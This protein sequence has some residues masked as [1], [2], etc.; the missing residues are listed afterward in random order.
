MKRAVAL[1]RILPAA[2]LLLLA[3]ALRTHNIDA[4]SLWFD[5]GWSAWAAI[6]PTLTDALLA[7]ETNPPLYYLLL[8]VSARFLG[9]SEFSLRLPSLWLTLLVVTLTWQLALRNFGRR[10]AWL[11]AWLAV[12]SAPLWW[13]AQEARMYALLATLT[14]SLL[15]AWQRLLRRPDDR[16][17]WLW[18]LAGETLILYTHNTGPV[19]ALWLNAVMALHWLFRFAQRQ[20]GW[21]A[22]LPD[23]RLWLA[24][25]A[26]VVLLWAPWLTTYFVNVAAANSALNDAPQPGLT[27]F[28]RMWASLWLAPW[29]LVVRSSLTGVVMLVAPVPLLL[30]PWRHPASRRLALH[31]LL[32]AGLLV[33]GLGLIGNNMHGRYLVPLVPLNIVLMSAGVTG[34]ARAGPWRLLSLLA[35]G[36]L[37]LNLSQAGDPELQHDD[38]RGMA[39]YYRQALSGADSVL[40]WSYAERYELGYY[41]RKL[42]LPATLITLPENAGMEQVVPLIPRHGRVALNQWYTQRAD[43][44]GMAGC[45]LAHGGARP[46]QAHAVHGMR[47]LLFD[48]A[49]ASTPVLQPMGRIVSVGDPRR[50]TLTAHGSLPPAPADQALCLPL[51][52]QAGPLLQTEVQASI[53]LRNRLGRFVGKGSAIFASDDQRSGRQARPGDTLSAWPVLRLPYG[54]MPGDYE[55]W[56]RIFDEA[57]AP[58]G[59]ELRSG[60]GAPLGSEILLGLWRTTPGADWA[61]TTRETE[62]P[63]RADL[64]VAD[65]LRLLA[66]DLTGPRLH[67]GQPLDISLLWEGEG[68]LP[69]LTLAAADDS[70]SLVL[71]PLPGQRDRI[72]LDWRAVTLPASASD[73]EVRLLLPDGRELAR[74][75]LAA[76]PLVLEAPEVA[77]V[78]DQPLGALATLTGFTPAQTAMRLLEKPEVTLVWQAGAGGAET[79]YT[80]FVHLLDSQGR[81]IAQSDA[82]PAGGTRPTSGWRSGEYIVD[83]HRL[84]FNDLAQPGAARLIVG[85]YDARTGAR[86][87]GWPGGADHL[88]LPIDLTLS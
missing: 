32:P 59:Y 69:D 39:R 67:P 5:E 7:D 25:Q 72:T 79:S 42:E 15:L 16:R 85:M 36:L 75:R 21:R 58:D 40:A 64:V 47:N 2:A 31:I 20:P 29:E 73:G 71:E 57:R 46:P 76:L 35:A 17:A 49:P 1:R 55:V 3:T 66:H 51:V 54:A 86:L 24:G 78:V 83:V 82:V 80:V 60:D 61:A 19:Y 9:D 8:N 18:L 70:W 87:A 23:W 77:F 74:R 52:M 33:L 56:L 53:V 22:W 4:Q 26:A 84:R 11:A 34:V 10:A 28:G 65:R 14:L 6:Q 48:A 12:W 63:V 37:L 50:A 43:Y 30:V 38:A 62:L 27:L 45:L 81:L 44:R 41:W 13:A 68:P 88:V